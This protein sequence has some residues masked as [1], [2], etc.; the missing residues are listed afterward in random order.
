MEESYRYVG[1]LHERQLEL[2]LPKQVAQ[3]EEQSVHEL[4]IEFKYF[5]AGQLYTHYLVEGFK[6]KLVMQEVHSAGF[7]IEQEA[8]VESQFLHTEGE[9]DTN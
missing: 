4:V 1:E 7:E 9:P 8:H 2:V 6:A 5:P 3:S